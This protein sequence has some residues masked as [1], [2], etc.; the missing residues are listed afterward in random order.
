MDVDQSGQIVDMGA[1]P[2]RADGYGSGHGQAFGFGSD[3]FYG[4]KGVAVLLCASEYCDDCGTQPAWVRNRYRCSGAGA[5]SDD[6][7]VD[8]G[9]ADGRGCA[10]SLVVLGEQ[11][12]VRD[13]VF[14]VDVSASGLGPLA[15]VPPAGCLIRVEREC[16]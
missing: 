3:V 5:V 8:R 16:G 12:G 13:E 6:C 4:E 11:V 2:V 15:S 1:Y 14:I 9:E 10:R 7:S